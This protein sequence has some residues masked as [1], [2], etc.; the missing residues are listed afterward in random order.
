MQITDSCTSQFVGN[1]SGGGKSCLFSQELFRHSIA[2]LPSVVNQSEETT[3][4]PEENVGVRKCGRGAK[5]ATGRTPWLSVLLGDVRTSY[6]TQAGLLSSTDKNSGD[7]PKSPA[8]GFG[9]IVTQTNH[10]FRFH[11]YPMRGHLRSCP[12][13]SE[14]PREI[15]G[16]SNE[17]K[18][19]ANS[20]I[21]TALA[22]IL[23]GS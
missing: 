9:Q 15:E 4:L 5:P 10:S 22:I 21:E 19:N 16:L 14:M 8:V 2:D 23:N 20:M 12:C 7:I 11:M 17:V 6:C 13:C 18:A 3:C 1:F